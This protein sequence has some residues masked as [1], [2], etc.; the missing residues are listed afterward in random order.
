M[1]LLRASRA[2]AARLLAR[3]DG[4]ALIMAVGIVGVL[5]I[6]AVA[7][8]EVVRATQVASTHERQGGRTLGS[9]ESGL[10]AGANAAITAEDAAAQAPGTTLSGSSTID[11]SSVSWTA[12]KAADGLTWTI[13]STATSAD[14]KVKRV[15]Q[16]TLASETTTT[17]GTP[18]DVFDYG[19]FMGDPS[20][21]CTVL[22]TNGDTIGNGAQV[23]VPIY[24]ASSLCL[25]GGSDPVI[26]NPSGGSA[27]SLY[28]GGKLRV[29]GPTNAV[30]TQTSPIAK[31][32][33]VGGCQVMPKKT[34]LNVP[35]DQHGSPNSNPSSGGGSGVWAVDGMYD[36]TADPKTKPTL[37]STEADA[38]YSSAAPGPLNLTSCTGALS[39]FD[40]DTTRNTS[41]GTL[42]LLYLTGSSGSGNDF[43]CKY[44]DGSGNVI[45]Q[46][47][48]TFG[49]PGTLV[50]KGKVFLDANL[51]FT[52]NDKAL[53]Q[54]NGTL[55]VNGTVSFTNGA[56]ICGATMSGTSC[57]GNWDPTQN[58]LEIVA[59]NAANA[60]P[61]WYM[62]GDAQFE[63]IAFLNGRYVSENGAWTQGPVI[64]DSGSLAGATKFKEISSL[65]DGGFGGTPPTMT[66]TWSV[67]PGSW[68]ECPSAVGC[69]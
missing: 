23:T 68:R 28:V 26:G 60:N 40:D 30:G 67:K 53:Y 47:K 13:T 39:R 52:G 58:S 12:A 19:F 44:L 7:A 51:V 59:I 61:G 6:S 17:P 21:D 38:A 14:G 55:Y 41:L 57:S 1:S 3:E 63:G 45:G 9:A 50:I 32:T 49:S 56:H 37:G 5:S 64:A 46:L 25:S 4:I 15:L 29:D 8:V 24:I 54:G 65:P 36:S 22:T 69:S 2:R 48:W 27:I 43:D 20:A 66:T 62:G 34:W 18:S 33:I 16:R 35:C 42:R 11:G 10:D 31:A